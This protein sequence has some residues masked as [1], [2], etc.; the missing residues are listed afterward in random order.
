MLFIYLGK[1]VT[2]RKSENWLYQPPNQYPIQSV[3]TCSYVISSMVF[4]QACWK[5]VFPIHSFCIK[6]LEL[7]FPRL[8]HSPTVSWKQWISLEILHNP[9]FGTHFF[10]IF[11][12]NTQIHLT[13]LKYPYCKVPQYPLI[14]F[15]QT[16]KLWGLVSWNRFVEELLKEEEEEKQELPKGLM[17][18]PQVGNSKMLTKQRT[19]FFAWNKRNLICAGIVV[20]TGLSI[21]KSQ[22]GYL[23][24]IRCLLFTFAFYWTSKAL[25]IP[26]WPQNIISAQQS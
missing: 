3:R 8:A 7:I 25:W 5:V 24:V 21:F 12:W 6:S 18:P 17:Q 20:F 4:M 26:F 13:F 10:K 16:G 11:L 9:I 14:I 23:N 2:G 19:D 15:W 22:T 1:Y